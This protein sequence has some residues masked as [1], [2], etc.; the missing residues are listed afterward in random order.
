MTEWFSPQVGPWFSLLSLL[1][2]YSCTAP[3]ISNGRHKTLVTGLYFA[4]IG[5]G[6]VFLG[7]GLVAKLLD[8]PG[9]V[10]GPLL[11]FGIVITVVFVSV[12]PAIFKGYAAAEQRKM[13]AR[14]I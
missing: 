11:L 2:L 6:L 7:L 12:M 14:D 8:Q 13:V 1:S 4:A 10:V 9:H 5:L 3:W